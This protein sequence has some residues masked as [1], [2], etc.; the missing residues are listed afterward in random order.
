MTDRLIRE[1]E[2]CAA[3]N[4]ASQGATCCT[5]AQK[6]GC[7]KLP[8]VALGKPL[9]DADSIVGTHSMWI[10]TIIPAVKVFFP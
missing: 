3:A 7:R 8:P 5:C 10:E 2:A 6:R 4:I 1:I 9:G